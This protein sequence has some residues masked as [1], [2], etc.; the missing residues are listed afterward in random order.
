MLD[1][2]LQYGV[3]GTASHAAEASI[4]KHMSESKTAQDWDLY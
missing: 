4:Q 1:N 3:Y 2:Y